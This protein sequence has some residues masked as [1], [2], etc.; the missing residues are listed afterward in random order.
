MVWLFCALVVGVTI[1]CF[2]P[3]K[4]WLRLLKQKLGRSDKQAAPMPEQ[5]LIEWLYGP[6][7][8]Q[9]PV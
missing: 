2:L 6:D 9:P 3:L 5:M 1:G 8:G 7:N 4:Q